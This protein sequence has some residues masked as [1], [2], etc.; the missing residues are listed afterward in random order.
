[1]TVMTKEKHGGA[2]GRE[3]SRLPRYTQGARGG[4]E[5][6]L[7]SWGAQEKAKRHVTRIADRDSTRSASEIMALP[8]AQIQYRPDGSKA[9]CTQKMVLTM[10]STLESR[11]TGPHDFAGLVFGPLFI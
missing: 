10:G 3:L 4:G 5:W 2:V 1:M 6:G 11:G 7:A 8:F 9:Y